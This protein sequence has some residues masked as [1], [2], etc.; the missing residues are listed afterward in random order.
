MKSFYLK[1]F[2]TPANVSSQKLK[3]LEAI[4][5]SVVNKFGE[6]KTRNYKDFIR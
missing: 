5:Q 2:M 4:N 6:K 3:E 1:N